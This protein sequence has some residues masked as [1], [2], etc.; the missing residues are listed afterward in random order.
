MFKPNTTVALVVKCQ[1]KF[2]LV[3]EFED[4]KV[5]Y[6]QPAGHLEANESLLDAAK[7]ELLEETGLVLE[8]EFIVG[9]YQ[10]EIPEKNIQYLRFCYAIELTGEPPVTQPQDDDITAAHWFT[11][12]QIKQLAPQHRSHMVQL[13]IDDYLLGQQY[14]LQAIQYC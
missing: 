14:A 11:L 13:C 7:R 10:S 8:P 3:E 5:V 12:D 6:N 1:E 4:G 2:L 9:I